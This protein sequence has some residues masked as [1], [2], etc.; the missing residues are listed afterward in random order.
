[1]AVALFTLHSYA[2]SPGL[3]ESFETLLDVQ[4]TNYQKKL[5]KL[6]TK[7]TTLNNLNNADEV[8]LDPDFINTILFYSP[9]R[10]SSLAFKDKCSFY[11]LYLAGHIRDENGPIQDFIIR[12]KSKKGDVRSGV[13]KAN[14]YMEKVGFV[15]C[16]NSKKFAQYFQLKNLPNTL[17]TLFLKT[18]TS[19]DQCEAIHNEFINDY[20][21]PYL[22]KI[23]DAIDEIPEL[24]RNLKNLSKSKYRE[25]EKIK[26]ELRAA[27]RYQKYLNDK[28][29]DYLKNI[30]DN[31]EKPKQF[32]HEYFNENFWKK[33]LKGEKS[34]TYIEHKCMA[35]LKI[36]KLTDKQIKKCVRDFTAFPELCHYL[37][38]YDKALAPRFNC[39][40]QS[41]ALN[42]SRLLADYNDCPSR[43]GNEG[44]TNVARVFKHF[45]LEKKT[46]NNASCEIET[47]HSFVAFNNEAS[48]GRFWGLKLCY[49]DKINRE[50]VC[51]PTLTGDYDDSEY[52]MSKVVARILAK[53][54]GYSEENKCEIIQD[55]DYKPLM[56]KFKA[57]CFIITDKQQCFGTNC[58]FKVILDEREVNL[59]KLKS[60][61]L[62]DY[63]PSNYLEENFAQTKLLERYLKKS[64]NKILNISFLKSTFKNHPL[65]IVQGIACAEDLLPTFFAKNILHK[66]TPLPFIID[67]YME[68]KGS[69]SLVIKTAMDDVHSPRIISWSYVFSALKAYKELHPL[70]LWGL[71]AIY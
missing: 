19:F 36:N 18:P 70:G 13:V 48:D 23:Y 57:G 56:L 3:Y 60:G 20:K 40:E 45:N 28:S 8:D 7:T 32:C 71:Y 67:G 59:I 33:I 69:L 27:L 54:R 10:Y 30:C 47:T 58:K 62:F 39:S 52:S 49:D 11:D 50:E 16:P 15:Q 14:I 38:E 5:E 24:Q 31:I 65:A 55:E 29:Y 2:Q 6:S 35:Y 17:K 37:N 46:D 68:D 9:S 34:K 63:F 42:Q 21:T 1:M 61:T 12:Y 44:I 26:R 66:C 53:T 43:I 64:I 41:L 25:I 4:K 22:C 51:F